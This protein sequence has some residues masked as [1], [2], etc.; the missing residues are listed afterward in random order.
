[1]NRMYASRTDPFE[2]SRRSYSPRVLAKQP[3]TPA[4]SASRFP[5]RDRHDFDDGLRPAGA[6]KAEHGIVSASVHESKTA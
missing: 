2:G 5:S 4:S 1:M 6:K 3:W